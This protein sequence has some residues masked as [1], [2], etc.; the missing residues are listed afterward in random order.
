MIR[1]ERKNS[2]EKVA[3]RGRDSQVTLT[4]RLF[5]LL[6]LYA[7]LIWCCELMDFFCWSLGLKQVSLL[8]RI[9]ACVL[10]VL[11]ARF[12]IGAVK[13]CKVSADGFFLLGCLI[14]TA[15]FAYKGIR[16]DQSYDT[17]NYHL[18]CQIP[19][20]PD[21]LNFHVMPGRFQMYGFRLG[22]RMFY[23]F[24]AILGLRMGTMLNA[25]VMLVIYRQMTVM[26]AWMKN[27]LFMESGEESDHTLVKKLFGILSRPSVL[28]FFVVCH[29][30]VLMQ[31]GSYMVELLAIPFLLEALFLLLRKERPEETNQQAFIFCLLLGLLFC[32]KMTNIIYAGPLVLFYLWKIRKEIKLP[33][34]IKCLAA[35]AIPVSIYLFYN[36]MSTGNPV[37]PYYNTIFHSPYYADIDFKD[38]RWGPQGLLELF[39]WPYYMIRY[40]EYRLSEVPCVYNLDLIAGYI[41]VAGLL[42]ASLFYAVKKKVII[43]KRELA[44]ILLYG[45]SFL[46]WAVTTGHTRYF[47]GGI[48]I[49]SLL[50]AL[51][52]LRMDNGSIKGLF[53]GIL[54]LLTL[55]GKTAYGFESVYEGKEWAMRGPDRGSTQENAR[56]IFRDQ[57]IFPQELKDRVDV[58][59]LTW[60]D[61]GSYA[62]LMGEQ[63]PVYNRFS[64]VNELSAYQESYLSRIDRYMR[65]GKGVYD[66]FPQGVETLCAYLENLNEIGYYTEE[67]IVPDDTLSGIQAFT[68][69]RLQPMDGRTNQWHC[70][71]GQGRSQSV[72]EWVDDRPFTFQK[73]A[74][75]NTYTFTALAGDPGFWFNP[76]PYELIVN[77]Y[78]ETGEKVAAVV[79][80]N[81]D[82]YKQVEIKLDLSGLT[83]EIHLDF[84]TSSEHKSGI[85][86]NPHLAAQHGVGGK[87]WI[88]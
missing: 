26:I 24:R 48:M 31:S 5:Y 27:R 43:Y 71:Q 42:S 18:L 28:A 22:D 72:S 44:L 59:L 37:F 19:G 25:A 34:F 86:I 56:F 68:F 45:I 73:A 55:V 46:G 21:N 77:A 54:L 74:D 11:I 15:F 62:R 13:F 3:Q 65:E 80:M 36:G 10:M 16:P 60:S 88:K 23:P 39:L 83:G 76:Q 81:G 69:A 58:M 66:M 12:A 20:F 33:L 2:N 87:Q 17:M 30:G 9:F 49:G 47:M 64:I 32:L 50:I 67:M 57:D 63:V 61:Y 8:S 79:Q 82:A 70:F 6:L 53:A 4:S 7:I 40:P 51:A 85:F 41:A 78:D 14:F 52:I 84:D 1:P 29:Q 38:K 75:S 35:G